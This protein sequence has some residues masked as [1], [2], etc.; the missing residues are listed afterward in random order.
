MDRAY[1]KWGWFVVLAIVGT[2]SWF[3]V[4]EPMVEGACHAIIYLAGV[5]AAH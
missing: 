3:M 2:A 5:L 4:I 1:S